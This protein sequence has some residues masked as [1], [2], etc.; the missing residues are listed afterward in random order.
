MSELLQSGGAT[1]ARARGNM[2][3]RVAESW[4][5]L[6]PPYAVF[7]MRIGGLGLLFLVALPIAV[8]RAVRARSPAIAV[9]AVA[10]L[11]TPDPAVARYI[12]AFPGLVLA[13]AVPAVEGLG[14]RARFVVFGVAA[15]AAA[16]NLVVAYP[17]LSATVRR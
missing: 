5:A 10:T 14:S 3:E 8:V 13:M 7:D 12:L 16:H 1:A 2:F 4:T 9:V 6:V 15:L 17:G 11:A